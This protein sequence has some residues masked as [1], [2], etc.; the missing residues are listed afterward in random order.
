[1]DWSTEE[2]IL[3]EAHALVLELNGVLDDGK[4]HTY[5]QSTTEKIGISAPSLNA[6]SLRGAKHE[7]HREPFFCC[8]SVQDVLR[9][10]FGEPATPSS[11]D[12]YICAHPSI[13]NFLGQVESDLI[14]WT[15]WVYGVYTQLK[16]GVD[17][18]SI[19]YGPDG[20]IKIRPIGSLANF[21]FLN[22]E[23]HSHE[24]Q[25]YTSD[26]DFSIG[27]DS[28]VEHTDDKKEF[29]LKDIIRTLD[30]TQND[31]IR[32]PME[33]VMII[34]GGPGV[35]K[36]TV[37]LHRIPYLINEQS[38]Y[39][40][41]ASSTERTSP[42][43]SPEKTLI[44]VWKSHL[45]PY[46]QKSMTQLGVDIPENNCREI[47]D[48]ILEEAKRLGLF[49]RDKHRINNHFPGT[50]FSNVSE[51][52]FRTY[53]AEENSSLQKLRQSASG[54]GEAIKSTF[55]SIEG[56]LPFM[57]SNVANLKFAG[58]D[59]E[60][61]VGDMKMRAN[62]ASLHLQGEVPGPINKLLRQ[63]ELDLF[64]KHL[65]NP[66][67]LFFDFLLSDIVFQA[68]HR[69]N[70]E[71]AGERF[72]EH[73][74]QHRKDKMVPEQ[75]LPLLLWIVSL[76]TEFLPQN[77]LRHL[78]TYTHTVVDEAQYF[79]PIVL[80]LLKECSN[81]KDK[82]TMTIVGD[83]EQNIS[84]SDG[85]A[86]WEEFGLSDS[87]ISN[88]VRLETSYRWSEKVFGFLKT[89]QQIHQLDENITEPR[90]WYS[91]AG[92]DVRIATSVT[93]AYKMDLIVGAI[94]ELGTLGGFD[95]QTIA[96]VTPF[97]EANPFVVDLLDTLKSCSITSRWAS[98]INVRESV[99][100]VVVTDYDSIVGL[101]FDAVFVI[102]PE[103]MISKNG[104]R[105]ILAIWVAITRAKRHLDIITDSG[106]EIFAASAFD[107]YRV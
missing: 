52:D 20:N 15:N 59:I 107:E 7:I 14:P 5:K 31:Q 45:V 28:L 42:R 105:G 27:K 65:L 67:D 22:G 90:S 1:M 72:Q 18:K 83:V 55:Q 106:A 17:P 103:K 78:T 58:N 2:Q 23:I 85:V 102:S 84:V 81:L 75:G 100:E 41:Q 29:G 51:D 30:L 24:F 16:N 79:A 68:I 54:N 38:G 56:A 8:V 26:F 48:W 70:G 3:E 50:E 11:V 12:F 80:R 62:R 73:M 74:R 101:E 35:G 19:K 95:F 88:I 33:G 57:P 98:G 6:M 93:A 86:H 47:H 10:E 76:T 97:D 91:G 64:N 104:P 4:Q 96:V 9:K 32:G 49:G 25:S 92:H 34:T 43:F 63:L 39:G 82:G 87:E 99:T 69:A 89:F 13:L 46:L 44:V 40:R 37:A 66:I 21:K 53:L 94:E 61:F 71:E 77:D 36:T 60:R